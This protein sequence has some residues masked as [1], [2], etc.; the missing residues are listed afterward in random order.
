MITRAQHYTKDNEERKKLD[1][2]LVK[3]IT[4]SMLPFNILQHEDFKNFATALN[5]KYPVPS[6]DQF[7][8]SLL[9]KVYKCVQE[10]LIDILGN[11]DHAGITTDL[12]TSPAN[13]AVIT[14]TVHFLYDDQLKSA[15]LDTIQIEAPHTGERIAEVF[16]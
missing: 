6:K 9:P 10:S 13:V 5:K 1:F 14:I 4:Y 2:L 16:L 3:L 8:E 15:V 12:W 11:I 7:R